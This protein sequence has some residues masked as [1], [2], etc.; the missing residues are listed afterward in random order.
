M[1]KN[2]SNN[3]R[4]P[5]IKL[6]INLLPEGVKVGLWLFAEETKQLVETGVVNKKW[7]KKALTK[8]NKIHSRGLLTNIEALYSRHLNSGFNQKDSKRDI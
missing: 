7:R 5:A 1:K 2:D 3:L 6:L 4:I 8:V